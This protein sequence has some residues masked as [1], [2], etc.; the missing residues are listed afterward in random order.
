MVATRL[1]NA[2][3]KLKLFVRYIFE[4]EYDDIDV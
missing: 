3:I 1:N 2:M 4:F